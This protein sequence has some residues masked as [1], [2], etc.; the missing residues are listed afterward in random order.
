MSDQAIELR[1][2]RAKLIN[3][4]ARGILDK[5]DAEKRQLSAEEKSRFDRIM[6]D[7]ASIKQDYERREK[8]QAEERELLTTNRAD[9]PTPQRPGGEDYRPRRGDPNVDSS[10]FIDV[11]TGEPLPVF[12]RD[13]ALSEHYGVPRGFRFGR[14][15]LARALNSPRFLTDCERRAME[16]QTDTGGG[17]M[18]SAMMGAGV[19]D[20]A[21]SKSVAVRAG[22]KIVPMESAELILAKIDT[23]PTIDWVGENVQLSETAPVFGSVRL[24][25]RTARCYIPISSELAADSANALNALEMAASGAIALALDK[26]VLFGGTVGNANEPIGLRRL[27]NVNEVTSVGTPSDYQKFADAMYQCRLNNAPGQLSVIAHPRTF[28]TLDKLEDT[29]GQPLQPLPSW[30]E[31]AKFDTTSISI[32]EG[33]NESF[34]IV[35]PMDQVIIGVR[36]NATILEGPLEA[37][38]YQRQFAVVLRADVAVP[39][40]KFFTRMLGITA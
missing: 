11:R 34:A 9:G 37:S 8:L 5:A 31:A 25:A 4:D 29:V 26:A 19:I 13:K 39:R 17:F 38:K 16:G 32:V 35:G 22:A 6:A 21:R 36:L 10:S 14:V 3:V 18:L 27:D 33:T 23:D 24:Q 30:N 28:N 1:E 15:L 2:K 20:L 12:G 7:A 40:P